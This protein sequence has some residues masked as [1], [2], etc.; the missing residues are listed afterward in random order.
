MPFTKTSQE[1]TYSI[2]RLTITLIK[3]IKFLWCLLISDLSHILKNNNGNFSPQQGALDKISD[4][5]LDG[6]HVARPF[7]SNF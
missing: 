7:G 4:N 6:L 1:Y 3:F 5:L 2:A